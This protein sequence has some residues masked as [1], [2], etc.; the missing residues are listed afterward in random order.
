[1]KRL[2]IYL[3]LLATLLAMPYHAKADD[4]EENHDYYWVSPQVT[5]NQK[6]PYFKLVPS[7]NRSRNGGDGQISSKYYTF[8]IQDEFIKRFNGSDMSDNTQIQ[9]YIVRDDGKVFYRPES[10]LPVDYTPNSYG[11]NYPGSG[12]L[13]SHVSYKNYWGVRSL[14]VRALLKHTHS[15]LM[16]KKDTSS[17][18]IQQQAA[19]LTLTIIS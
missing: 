5:N 17:S 4:N 18:T 6:Q 14:S 19:L 12:T 16:Q 13:D 7:R 9:W 10:E 2:L 11:N 1:M 15:T 8:T 3:G